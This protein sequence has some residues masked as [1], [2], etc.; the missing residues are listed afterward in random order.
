MLG[1]SEFGCPNCGRPAASLPAR[2]DPLGT[3]KFARL[4]TLNNQ[5]ILG[6][7]G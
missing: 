5:G 4:V 1:A 7:R 6:E 2:M 3:A